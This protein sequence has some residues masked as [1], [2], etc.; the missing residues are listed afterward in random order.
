MYN[1]QKHYYVYIMA[2]DKNGTLYVG[3]TNNLPRRIYEHK[4]HFTPGFTSKYDVC[5]LV[6]FEQF[7]DVRL[8]IKHEK[9]LKEWQRVWKK[10]LI[11][12]YNP[13][14]KDLYDDLHQLV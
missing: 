12:K 9:R 3:F 7:T 14:W 6:Y 13:E 4:H 8:A 1:E 2:S 11:E 5:K 10:D